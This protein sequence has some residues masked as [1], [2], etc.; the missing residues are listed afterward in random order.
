M[1]GYDA[2][3]TNVYSLI[4]SGPVTLT[5]GLTYHFNMSYV[6]SFKGAFYAY[7]LHP[8]PL[9]LSEGTY[10]IGNTGSES[11]NAEIFLDQSEY[12][13]EDTVHISYQLFDT[14]NN[15]MTRYFDYSGARLIFPY[16]TV[17]NP[18]GVVIASNPNTFDFFNFDFKLPN[19]AR[20]GEYQVEVSI[21]QRLKSIHAQTY[22]RRRFPR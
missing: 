9:L 15:Q 21:L 19:S 16:V 11:F 20:L 6:V 22:L 10:H 17:R 14:R 12:H 5:S 2:A 8:K 3:Y 4:G 1:I 18:D 13:P 7:E